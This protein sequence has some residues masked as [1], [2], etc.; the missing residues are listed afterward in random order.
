MPKQAITLRQLSKQYEQGKKITMLTCY[1]AAFASIIDQTDL[2]MILVGDS[3]AMVCHGFPDTT[4]ATLEM[5]CMHTQAVARA[6]P[7]QMIVSDL[8]FLSYRKGLSE[9]MDAVDQLL[10]A[11][12]HAIKLEG[13]DGNETFIQ[14]LVESGVP[15]MGHLGLTPQHVHQMGGFVIQGRSKQQQDKLLKDAKQLE[16]LGCFA[17]VLEC[18]PAP[19]ASKLSEQIAMPVIGIGAGPNVD[20]QVLVLHD[21]LGISGE[22]LRFV[23]NQMEGQQLVQTAIQ[24]YCDQVRAL[25][26][27]EMEHAFHD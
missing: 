12:A 27:P 26:F 21:V 18:V 3:V 4:H 14:H 2:D 8:P 5:M 23:K 7:H 19:L 6:Q 17:M 13:V 25:A 10:K 9:G 24:A 22:G 16:A 15:V 1:D 20:G 11:G